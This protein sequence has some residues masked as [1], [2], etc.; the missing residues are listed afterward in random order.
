MIKIMMM[1]MMIVLVMMVM[2]V[3]VLLVVWGKGVWLYWCGGAIKIWVFH[4]R[5]RF[6]WSRSSCFL[7]DAF[8]WTRS[9]LRCGRKVLRNI[10]TRL[11]CICPYL[12]IDLSIVSKNVFVQIGKCI[13]QNYI[14]YLSTIWQSVCN[15][16]MDGAREGEAL[17]RKVARKKGHISLAS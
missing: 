8:I 16:L 6:L 11:S 1:M 9:F 12:K 5:L 15:S 3:I 17:K 13:C 14:M 7:G 2:M 4:T 10:L